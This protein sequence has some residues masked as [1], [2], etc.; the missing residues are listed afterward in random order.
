VL[1]SIN[2][3][4]YLFTYKKKKMKKIKLDTSKFR[5][6]K[7]KVS[8]LTNDEL[9]RLQGGAYNATLFGC[10]SAAGGCT[11]G[12]GCQPS[13]NYCATG[14]YACPPLSLPYCVSVAGHAC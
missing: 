2:F 13:T 8:D 6:E 1:L 3:F 12:Y 14:P 10:V 7:E 11:V 9:Q 4:K 5:L